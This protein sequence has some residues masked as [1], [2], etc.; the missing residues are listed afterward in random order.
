MSK[1]ISIL[2]A[3]ILL[4]GL[5]VPAHAITK[6]EL[7]AAVT[8]TAAYIFNTVREPQVGVIGG[9]WTVIGLARSGHNV[10]DYYFENYYRAVEQYVRERSGVLHERRFTDHSRVI[11]GL[12]A[13]GY[14]PRDVAGF[15]L[16]KPLGDFERTLWQGINGAIWALIALDSL[17][18]P[19]PVNEAANIQATREM[20][21]TEILRRQTPD[22]GWNLTAGVGGEV[23]R[24]ERGDPALT[25]MAL[26]ALA[27]YQHMARV[28]AATDEALELLS[29]A[30][31]NDGG[32]SG[33]H[34]GDASP[35]V[36]STVQVLTAL[37]EL[38]IPFDDPRF[39]KNGNTFID[40][41]LS[42]RN[43]DGSFNHTRD[44]DGDSLMSTEQA[45]YGLAAAQRAAE[46]KNSLYRMS[47]TLKRGVFKPFG[48]NGTQ[49]D[50]R[51]TDVQNHA[52]Q[53]AIEALASRGIING[54]SETL[55]DP[56]ATM[57]RAEFAA[58]IT[59]GLDLPERNITAFT[60]VSSSAW[61]AGAVG[62]AYYHEII[63]GTTETTFTP[64]RV[65]TRQ[66]AEIMVA[67]AARLI[68]LDAP[69]PDITP[70]N[71]ISRAEIAEML[72][73]LL[74]RAERL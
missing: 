22:G 4:T 14:D 6:P 2:I 45:L 46:G 60:D 66:E 21:I 1:I 62:T 12:T 64:H 27:K 49:V 26:Q 70:N 17:D 33:G 58:I 59:R 13:A 54:R 16:T 43:S 38:G 65:I 50:M 5:A 61:Y 30:Q 3:V 55:F 20:Y 41:I 24:N 8:L 10:P 35:A 36:E 69:A 51:F 28:K 15:D 40:S 42:Y 32:Y 56:D 7:D 72:Y 29:K 25:G 74:E 71:T 52:N 19:M 57:T 44:G 47:D 9:E 37:C 68:G 63:R 53:Q 34:L 67:R 11:L 73:R 31:N 23:G 39:V 48:E 18:Y